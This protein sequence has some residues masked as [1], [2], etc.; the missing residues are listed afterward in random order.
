MFILYSFV[1]FFEE[2]LRDDNPFEYGRWTIYR[3]GTISQNLAIYMLIFGVVLML[4]FQK[5][6]ENKS[7]E[8]INKKERR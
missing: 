8:L 6:S 4:I 7:S 2:F 1:R 5:L 3:G